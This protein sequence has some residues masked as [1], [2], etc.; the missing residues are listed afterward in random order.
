MLRSKQRGCRLANKLPAAWCGK[1]I[2]PGLTAT[3]ANRTCGYGNARFSPPRRM[4]AVVKAGHI[5][6][7]WLETDKIDDILCRSMRL[8]NLP[9]R[10]PAVTGDLL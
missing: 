10:Q 2:D 6:K 7:A 4:Q 5:R 1:G 8:Y 9:G 3:D